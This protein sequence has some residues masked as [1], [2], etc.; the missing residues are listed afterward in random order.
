MELRET[1]KWTKLPN[2]PPRKTM[3]IIT[4]HCQKPKLN[5]FLKMSSKKIGKRQSPNPIFKN[6]ELSF[7]FKTWGMKR[8]EEVIM[9]RLRL[10]TCKRLKNFL[11]K[12]GKHPDRRCETC[13]TSDDIEHFLLVCPKYNA[14]RQIL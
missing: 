2:R 5:L 4:S 1:K 12:I 3:L 11:Y 14:Q 9:H 6:C 10:G 13:A 8:R 7:T